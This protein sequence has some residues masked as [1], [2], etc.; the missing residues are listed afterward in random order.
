MSISL[1]HINISD[2]DQI[3]LDKVNYNFDQLVANGGGPRG[4]QGPIGQSG[5]Q[6]TTGPRGFQGPLGDIGFQGQPGAAT[7]EYWNKIAP[8]AIN[9]DTLIPKHTPDQFAPVINIGHIETDPEYGPT[10]K[11]PLIGGK[12]PYQW[13][14]NR[15]TYSES[16]LRF[17]NNIINGN[18]YDFKLEFVDEK[19]QMS[20]GFLTID[21]SESEYTANTTSFKSDITSPDNLYISS[22]G[23]FFKQNTVFNSPVTISNNLIIENAGAEENKIAIAENNS[24]KVKFKSVQD[25]GGTVPFGTIVSILPSIFNDNTNT[26]FIN[27]ESVPQNNTAPLNIS[28]GKG[29]GSYE[30]WYLCNGKSWTDGTPAG[31]Y[32][33]PTLGKFNYHIDDNPNSDSPLGQGIQNTSNQY[34]HITGGSDIDMNVVSVPSLI[35]NITSTVETSAVQVG[36]GTGT[37]F[38]IKQLPQIIYLGVKDLYWF[39]PGTGQIP[40]YA[41]NVLLND[42][43]TSASKLNPNPYNLGTSNQVAGASHTFTSNEVS[44]PAGYYWSANAASIIASITGLPGYMSITGVTFGPGA[45]PTTIQI[46]ISVTDHPDVNTTLTLGINTTS[47]ISVISATHYYLLSAPTFST[48]LDDGTDGALNST[49]QT[50]QIIGSTYSFPV[51]ITANSGYYFTQTEVDN[52]ILNSATPAR[53]QLSNVLLVNSTT[54]N[55]TITDTNFPSGGG[56][57]TISWDGSTAIANP[58]TFSLFSQSG[59]GVSTG[60]SYTWNLT[61]APQIGNT[62]RLGIYSTNIN[63]IIASTNIDSVGS[64]YAVFLN[65]VTVAQWKAAGVYSYTQGNPVGF[66]PTA[67]YDSLNNRLTFNMN[68]ANTISPPN[69]N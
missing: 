5:P 15:E 63:Y 2:S 7:V 30:G 41:F 46:G 21:N 58:L 57:T 62:I 3:K 48:I 14:I 55:A 6:G 36:P 45:K 69:V 8:G 44:A 39:D 66:K 32:Q 40:L 50:E 59:T 23:T 35:Y 25:L 12:T 4:P 64:S 29:V 47:I 26:K 38:R 33:V 24:G 49:K 56:T 10:A 51:T 17:L 31:T 18:G 13:K 60:R 61:G 68:W 54:I 11:L 22:A 34:N 20:F 1:K 52:L 16:N 19:D 27:T 28:V 37:T 43:N 65:N 53:I 67:Y 42:A 9:L